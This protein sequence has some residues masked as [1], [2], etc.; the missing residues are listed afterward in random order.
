MKRATVLDARGKELSP[1]SEDRARKLVQT[2]KAE[3]LSEDPLVIRLYRTVE[4]PPP[5]PREAETHPLQGKKLLLHI[6]CGPCATYSVKRLREEGAEVTG[7]WFNPN[8]HPYSEHERRRESLAHLAE[9]IELPMIWEPGYEMPTFLRAVVG[10]ERFGERCLICYRMRL[11]RTAQVAAR[12]GFELFTTTLLISPYQ[13]QRAIKHIG[14]ELA[15]QYGVPFYFENLRRGFAEHYR[16]AREYG[17][18]MQRYCGCIY[19]EWESLD[20][21]ASTHPRRRSTPSG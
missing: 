7:Y 16:L 14:E 11:E 17:L 6:C 2:G 4:L 19:S 13:N 10:H 12:E 9:Q 18:Y 21:E 15:E 8:I 3:L 1:C 20:P 5:K